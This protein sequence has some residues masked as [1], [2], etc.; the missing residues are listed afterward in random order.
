MNRFRI[1]IAALFLVLSSCA[2]GQTKID[3]GSRVTGVLPGAN[4]GIT[5]HT[6]NGKTLS[7]NPVLTPYDV[8]AIVGPIAGTSVYAQGASAFDSFNSIT[9]YWPSANATNIQMVFTNSY[10]SPEAAG[11]PL[12][13]T[14]SIEY[15]AGKIYPLFFNGNYAVTA[16]PGATIVSDPIAIDLVQGK[17]FNIRL[18]GLRTSGAVGIP[19]GRTF[20]LING[21]MLTPNTTTRTGGYF[22]GAEWLT[23]RTVT[24]GVTN[25][26]TTVTSATV[27]FGTNAAFS[28]T[29]QILTVAGV[30]YTIVSVTNS[31]TAIL[32][33]SPVAGTGVTFQ[34]SSSDKTQSGTISGGV[35]IVGPSPFAIIGQLG[36][37][38]LTAGFVGDS[39]T[40][41]V[42]SNTVGS[43]AVQAV[44]AG[45]SAS[46]STSVATAMPFINASETGDQVANLIASHASRFALLGRVKYILGMMGIN[47]L[48]GG[49]TAAQLEANLVT[50][51]A[52]ES[53]RGGKPYYGTITP[54][55]VS[56]DGWLTLAN[57]SPLTSP[58]GAETARVAV[59]DWI[60]DGAPVSNSTGLPVAIG[61]ATATTNRAPFY[62]AG[63][64]Q[65]NPTSGVSTASGPGTH[66][67][68]GLFE[69]A[70]AVET[71]QDSG[72]WQVDAGNRTVADGAITAASNVLTSAT[73]NFQTTDVGHY[74]SVSG[75]GTAGAY[76]ARILISSRTNATT[77]VLASNAVTTVS[78]A[79]VTIDG[80]LSTNMMNNGDGLH[81]GVNGHALMGA[82]AAL[83]VATWH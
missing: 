81:P 30:P 25:G 54:H 69:L 9:P 51:W 47:D 53:M 19:S 71:A 26:T 10:G 11:P 80:Q 67:A 14:A 22:D 49:Y 65:V 57:Q 21:T 3:L 31:T 77:V 32:S 59:N 56:T 60:R 4:G 6:V 36:S 7:T 78:G 83:T 2:F 15:P 58:A 27:N 55:N 76:L 64:P 12:T 63:V 46:L 73:A 33:G 35:S 39:I 62:V 43:W 52:Q 29:G 37:S 79:S 42:G 20:G 17:I 13:L 38:L 48:T 1:S 68:T 40:F 44:N 66:P 70:N 5:G 61:S 72:V 41:G 34:V 8:G 82:A 24:D 23:S 28:D 16:S 18:H 50:L 74:V 75:A 45:A